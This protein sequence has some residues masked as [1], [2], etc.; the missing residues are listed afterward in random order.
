MVNI[1]LEVLV[2]PRQ[3]TKD[4]KIMIV[5]ERLIIISEQ[6]NKNKRGFIQLRAS[7]PCLLTTNA[8]VYVLHGTGI[9][10]RVQQLE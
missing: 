7:L 10:V 5:Q 6:P 4:K 8:W 9:I 1:Q 3:G 2:R